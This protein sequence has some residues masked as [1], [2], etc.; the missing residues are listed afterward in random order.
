METR[1]HHLLIG[2][3]MLIL[4]GG[5]FAFVI[6]LAKVD[7]DQK[8]TDYSIYFEGSVAG[9][10]K[11]SAVRLNGVPV[12]TVQ[13]IS[14]P[15]EDPSKVLVD[16]RIESEVPILEGSVARLELQGFTGIAFVQISGGQGEKEITPDPDTGQRIIPSE[17]SPIQQVFEEAPNLINEA[18]LAVNNLK[19]LLNAENRDRIAAILANVETLSADLNRRDAELARLLAQLDQA[20]GDFRTMAQSFTATADTTRSVMDEDVREAFRKTAETAAA[21]KAVAD[22]LDGLVADNREGVSRFVNTALPETTRLVADLRRLSVRLNRVLDTIAD[23]PEQIL[24]GTKV[25]E[26]KP[27][28]RK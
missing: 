1:A 25:P 23:H 17:Q 16:V 26:Y 27:E 7:V 20:I 18:I 5:L 3:F 6:W 10:N 4:I 2:T 11:G 9:L 21:I 22:E 24:F 19:Q 13:D 28:E 12:G 8:F 14:I 15:R